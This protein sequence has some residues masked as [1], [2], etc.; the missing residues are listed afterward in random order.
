MCGSISQ[1]YIAASSRR[2]GRLQGRPVSHPS[3]SPS[4]SHRMHPAEK[5]ELWVFERC[6]LGMSLSHWSW[7]K[8]VP[9]YLLALG[10]RQLGPAL[11]RTHLKD[12]HSKE[13]TCCRLLPAGSEECVNNSVQPHCWTLGRAVWGGQ[14]VWTVPMASH[15]HLITSCEEFT[16]FL[17]E[18]IQQGGKRPNKFINKKLINKRR[19]GVSS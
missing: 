13:K 19:L 1:W 2:L 4:A 16:C 7:W 6:C 10:L 12:R 14:A 15:C 18:V 3:P 17:G 5:H 9:T 11:G 8:P